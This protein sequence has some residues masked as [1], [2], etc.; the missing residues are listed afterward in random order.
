MTKPSRRRLAVLTLAAGCLSLSVLCPPAMAE[1]AEPATAG[2][3][4]LDPAADA[5]GPLLDALRADLGA[6]LEAAQY[7]RIK[8]DPAG[9]KNVLTSVRR[10][11]DALLAHQGVAYVALARRVDGGNAVSVVAIYLLEGTAG[12]AAAVT[13]ADQDAGRGAIEIDLDSDALRPLADALKRHLGALLPAAESASPTSLAEVI[14]ALQAH[15][16]VAYVL[17]TDRAG[18]AL[19]GDS[20][21][22]VVPD[23]LRISITDD[24]ASV[25]GGPPAQAPEVELVPGPDGGPPQIK[26]EFDPDKYDITKQ[27]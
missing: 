3:R 6:L 24:A 13:P 22:F 12:D 21:A 5:T 7:R 16:Q 25:V 20:R 26:F 1:S 4:S 23:V 11:V 2:V 14:T 19:V 8:G 15:R 9:P 10:L 17:L 27:R 18:P